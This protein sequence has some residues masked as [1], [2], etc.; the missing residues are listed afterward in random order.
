[1]KFIKNKILVLGGTGMLGSALIE[2]LKKKNFRYIATSRKKKRGFFTF[3]ILKNN[4]KDLPK[5]D[6]VINCIGII[7]KLIHKKNI[8]ETIVINSLFPRILADHCEKIG[9][10]LIHITTDCVFSGKKGKYSELDNPDCIDIYGKTKSLGEPENCMV[11]RTSIIGE[12]TYNQRSLIEWMK[13]KKEKKIKGFTNHYWNGL[14]TKHLSEKILEIITKN[15]FKKEVF[16]IFSN[17]TLSKYKLLKLLNIKFKLNCEII[18]FKTDNS[19]NR[20]LITSKSLQ[21]KL[22]IQNINYQIKNIN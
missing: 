4:I 11:I 3:N 21:K 6:Y 12:E 7:N 15:L 14:T 1:M 13:S 5:C 16:H 2:V 20:S 19:I 8:K 17:E 9:T 10:K 18:K 22:K